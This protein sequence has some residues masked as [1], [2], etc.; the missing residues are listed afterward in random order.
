APKPNRR[1]RSEVWGHRDFGMLG[2]TISADAYAATSVWDS[3][4]GVVTHR[5]SPLAR[6]LYVCANNYLGRPSAAVR[7]NWTPRKQARF[8]RIYL[9][10]QVTYGR[11]NFEASDEPPVE[12]AENETNRQLLDRLPWESLIGRSTEATRTK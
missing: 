1:V 7:A 4:G 6:A 12:L 11:P 2:K 10:S 3:D 8:L 9:P 5:K